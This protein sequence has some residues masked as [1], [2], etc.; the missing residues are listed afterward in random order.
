MDPRQHPAEGLGAV[1]KLS[2][3]VK[4]RVGHMLPDAGDAFWPE[5]VRLAEQVVTPPDNPLGF[6]A[7]A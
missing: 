3:E 2:T 6:K 4:N 1:Q 5:V 7:S